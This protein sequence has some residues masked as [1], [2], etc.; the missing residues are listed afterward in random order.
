MKI[1][2][3]V[4]RVAPSTTLQSG[5]IGVEIDSDARA[6]G[7]QAESND[8]DGTRRCV[9]SDRVGERLVC[10]LQS[11]CRLFDGPV[12]GTTAMPGDVG[13]PICSE[14]DRAWVALSVR[15]SQPS[16][17]SLSASLSI[18]SLQTSLGVDVS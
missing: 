9:Q 10:V 12:P 3:C 14:N 5:L 18:P 8:V 6:G 16:S 17:I 13:G 2:L 1:F 15:M 4:D 11:P 7:S